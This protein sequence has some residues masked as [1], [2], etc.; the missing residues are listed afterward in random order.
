M[1]YP[2][3]KIIHCSF[4]F[5]EYIV[6]RLPKLFAV[7]LLTPLFVACSKGPSESEVEGLI[8]AQYQ[9][10]NSA[11]NSAMNSAS[12]SAQDQEMAKAMGNMMAGMMPKL[13]GVDDVNCDSIEGENT[14]MCT[15]N[16]KQTVG[17]NSS[18]NKASFKVYKVNDEWVLGN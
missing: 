18:N 1:I 17:G 10:A 9:Q 3:Y 2:T 12:A 5:K 14:Y 8:E 6:M 7:L 11:M 4:L 13:E 15:A 16:I